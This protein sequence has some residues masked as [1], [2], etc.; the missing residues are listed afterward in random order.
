MTMETE[1]RTLLLTVCD[2]VFNGPAPVLTPRPYV[3][4]QKFGGD[5]VNY[6]DDS[7]PSI[8]NGDFQIN[9]WSET[10]S[11]A[12]AVIKEIEAA[13]ITATAFS[14]RP[15][16]ASATDYDHDML[17]YSERQDFTIWGNR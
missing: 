7:V 8:Q 4:F 2:R 12:A 15:I 14:A 3:T 16:S 1:L 17:R 11:E 6:V 10:S 9:V 5:V 13:L